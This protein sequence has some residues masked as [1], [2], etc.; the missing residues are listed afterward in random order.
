MSWMFGNKAP[1]QKTLQRFEMISD[2]SN[3]FYAW[4]GDLY[5]SDIV[6]SCIRPK[7]KAIGK[8]IAKHIRDSVDGFKEN[9]NVSIRFLLEEPNPLMTGQMLQEKMATQLELNH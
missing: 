4:G 6:R 5:A 3:G 7:A 2:Q 1:E 8:L 9:P